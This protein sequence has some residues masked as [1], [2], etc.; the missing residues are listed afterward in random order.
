MGASFTDSSANECSISAQAAASVAALSLAETFWVGSG[1]A[2]ISIVDSIGTIVSGEVTVTA[3]LADDASVTAVQT[4]SSGSFTFENLPQRTIIFDAVSAA[5][6]STGAVGLIGG[7]STT[8]SLVGFG[9]PSDIDNNDFSQG[10]DGWANPDA[11]SIMEHLEDVGPE[12]DDGARRGRDLEDAIVNQDFMLFTQPY[13]GPTS[14]SRTFVSEEGT[15][16]VRVRYRFETSEYP[17]FYLTEYNDFF[18]VSIRSEVVGGLAPEANAMNGL[19]AAAFGSGTVYPST[20]WRELVLPVSADGD[21]IQ[22]DVTVANVGD[23]AVLSFVYIDFVEELS[24]GLCIYSKASPN[25]KLI[26]GHAAIVFYRQEEDDDDVMLTTYGLWPDSNNCTNDN[27]DATDI[28]EDLDCDDVSGYTYFYC[29]P[30]S[31]EK[32]DVLDGL[33]VA[34]VEWTCTNTC[35]SFASDTFYAVTGKDVDAD[36]F[37]GIET[38]REISK[39]ILAL[40]GG[41][42]IPKEG[43]PWEKNNRRLRRVLDEFGSSFPTDFLA[44]CNYI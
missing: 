28:R 27:G 43:L 5:D 33:V 29:E 19:G 6:G 9:E 40:N 16:G 3:Q 22:V 39:S 25:D 38:P 42:S 14:T 13:E 4:G 15:T 1:S 24:Q 12:A 37:L 8:I 2:T 11:A 7:G 26:S 21:I 10:T 32:K 31:D 17:T 20:G 44:K 30:I 23:G 34:N 36:D 18:K 41:T 35:A